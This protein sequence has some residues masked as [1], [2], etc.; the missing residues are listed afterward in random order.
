MHEWQWWNSERKTVMTYCAQILSPVTCRRV[1]QSLISDCAKAW[2]WEWIY[3]GKHQINGKWGVSDFWHT[4]MQNQRASRTQR[5]PQPAVWLNLLN[6]PTRLHVISGWRDSPTQ[7]WHVET[8]E[9]Y[10]KPMALQSSVPACISCIYNKAENSRPVHC[11]VSSRLLLSAWACFTI[12]KHP[13]HGI[14]VCDWLEELPSS[15]QARSCQRLFGVATWLQQR[16]AL[17]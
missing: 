13:K 14:S 3:A 7:H 11:T 9:C 6:L 4:H 5:V 15:L 1:K 16:A 17:F 12:G 8:A 2:Q 10:N